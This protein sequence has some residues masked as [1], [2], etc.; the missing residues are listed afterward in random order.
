MNEPENCTPWGRRLSSA[1]IFVLAAAIV[2][3]ALHTAFY[4]VYDDTLVRVGGLSLAVFLL[5]LRMSAAHPRPKLWQGVDVGLG[6][7]FAASMLHY[8]SIAELLETGLWFPEHID[9]VYGLAGLAVLLELARRTVG[10]P[11]LL[12][13]VLTIAYGLYGASLGETLGH[14]GMDL[15]NLTLTLWYSF[16]GVFG[17]PLAVVVDTIV[18]FII[19]GAL[20]EGLG[21]GDALLKLA[22]RSLGWLR[23]GAAHAA[24]LAS[25]LFGTVS[26]SA[27]ANV[28]ATGVVTIPMI[29]RSGFSARFAGA[30]EAA[31]S[32]GGQIT[33]PIMGAVAFIMAD[34]TGIPYLSICVAALLP[35]LLYYLSLFACIA[36]EAQ[37]AGIERPDRA[38]L[39]TLNRSDWAMIAVF[40]V[41]LLIVVVQLV[42]GV[43]PALAG[44]WAVLVALVFGLAANPQA[45]SLRVFSRAVRGAGDASATVIIAVA[46]VGVIVGVMNYTGIGL[47]FAGAALSFADGSLF[48]SLLVMAAACLVLGMGMPTVPAYLV[49]IL[50]MGPAVEALGVPTVAAHLF[51]IYFAVMSA[52]TPPVSLAAFAAAPIANANP[53]GISLVAMRISL[54]GFV[55]PFVFAYSPSLLLITDFSWTELLWAL[56][57][58]GL[59]SWLLATVFTCGVAGMVAGLLALLALVSPLLGLQLGGAVLG[60]AALI[61]RHKGFIRATGP[62]GGA[63]PAPCA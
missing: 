37:R 44:F 11:L 35:A 51:V 6:L 59:A 47:R 48:L 54:L 3:G 63:T 32:S 56:A 33:P 57:R 21:I 61:A 27:V 31:A 53:L 13:C 15:E 50:V 4:G 58:L 10:F 23:G 46:A 2:L 43:S 55:V 20:M 16:E 62:C 19:F 18:V 34:L 9:L 12:V 17:R 25:A 29:R 8:A 28:V 26:G 41:S 45:R 5:L 24:V 60:V 40:S 49:I 1:A 36:V 14:A 38:V 52:I 30:V 7:V 39:P 22:V 42:R